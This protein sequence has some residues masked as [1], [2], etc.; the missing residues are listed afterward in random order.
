MKLVERIKY[1]LVYSDLSTFAIADK[2][3]ISER[4]VLDIAQTL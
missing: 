2:L 1:F 3:G 4:E